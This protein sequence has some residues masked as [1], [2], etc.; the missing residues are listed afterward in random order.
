MPALFPRWTNTAVR[1][2]LISLAVV[3]PGVPISVM[4]WQRTPGATGSGYSPDQPVPFNHLLHVTDFRIDC[5]YCHASAER[6]SVAGL[7]PS[8][9]C[10]ACHNEVWSNSIALAPVRQSLATN[11]PVAWNR[12]NR[13]PDFVYFNHSIHVAKGVG[14]ETCHGRV[15]RMSQ[16]V[17]T[18]PLT[19]QWCVDCH[20]NPGPK[21]RPV[22]E[23]TVMGRAV[24]ADQ[25]ALGDE[26]V[27]R[28]KVRRLTNCTTCHR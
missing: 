10:T 28:Y 25:V 22:D 23:I 20:A 16:V 1:T 3:L 13:L 2:V 27:R 7:P 5:R 18:A 19:M 9:A 4:A 21:L 17:R 6:S 15:D 11:R 14:C 12:V 24:G 8:S 26:L